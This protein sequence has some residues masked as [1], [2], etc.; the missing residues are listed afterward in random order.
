MHMRT[1]RGTKSDKF[2]NAQ[3]VRLVINQHLD[4]KQKRRVGKLRVT[5]QEGINAESCVCIVETP[6]KTIAYPQVFDRRKW[7]NG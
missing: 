3:T 4:A 5:R 1:R 7:I 6:Y 2:S